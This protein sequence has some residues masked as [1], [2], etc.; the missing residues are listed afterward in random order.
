LSAVPGKKDTTP[1]LV[2]LKERRPIT[3]RR[4]NQILKQLFFV[5]ADLLPGTAEHKKD[6]LRAASAHWGRHTAITAKVDSGMGQRYVQKDA[7]HN[8]PRTTQRYIHEEEERWH[9]EA[10]KQRMRWTAR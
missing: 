1:L 3:A 8:D 10:Q 7:R 9:D 5:A 4:L 6:K 2:S